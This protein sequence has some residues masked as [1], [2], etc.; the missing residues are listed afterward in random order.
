M[1]ARLNECLQ[2]MN[3][4]KEIKTKDKFQIYVEFNK[5]NNFFRQ[6]KKKKKSN[7]CF[8]FIATESNSILNGAALSN[9][10]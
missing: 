7:W 8:S 4:I 1:S 6:S 3:K 10:L 2:K 9:G 5:C